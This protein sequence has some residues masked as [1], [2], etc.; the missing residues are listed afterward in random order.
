M[1]FSA[2]PIDRASTY[3]CAIALAE[4]FAITH[5]DSAKIYECTYVPFSV[6]VDECLSRSIF[7]YNAPVPDLRKA[8]YQLQYSCRHITLEAD[9][10]SNG[11]F[12]LVDDELDLEWGELPNWPLVVK[13]NSQEGCSEDPSPDQEQKI[14]DLRPLARVAEALSVTDSYVRR[15]PWAVLEVSYFL[16]Q[17]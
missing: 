2:S 8:I 11:T 9:A 13:H 6:D 15:R 16:I 5:E 12:G 3:L 7:R 1:K 10:Q 4:G 14:L 17:C